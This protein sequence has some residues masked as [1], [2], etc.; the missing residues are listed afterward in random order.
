MYI[1]YYNLYYLALIKT[2]QK[3]SPEKI[4]QNGACLSDSIGDSDASAASSAMG[5]NLLDVMH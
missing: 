2:R 4:C 1:P 5:T 3:F